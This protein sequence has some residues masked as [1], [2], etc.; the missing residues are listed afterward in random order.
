MLK[1]PGDQVMVVV[2]H[3]ILSSRVKVLLASLRADKLEPISKRRLSVHGGVATRFKML[4][5]YRVCSAFESVC[6]LP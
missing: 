3:K 4:T 1:E 2:I 5:Y 6:A